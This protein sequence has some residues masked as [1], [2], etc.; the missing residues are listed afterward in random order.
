MGANVL[1]GNLLLIR[2]MG[3]G[4]VKNCKDGAMVE[5]EWQQK[6]PCKQLKG[7]LCLRTGIWLS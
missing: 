4:F 1:D 7:K 5:I 3:E 2:Q 6:K